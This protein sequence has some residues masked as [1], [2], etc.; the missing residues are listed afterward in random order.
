MIRELLEMM[1]VNHLSV[2]EISR[3]TGQN[4]QDLQNQV[5][6]LV[7]MGYMKKV[8]MDLTGCEGSC[9]GCQTKRSFGLECTEGSDDSRGT[10]PGDEKGPMDE[11]WGYELTEKGRKLV[12]KE[13]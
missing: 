11:I 6:M 1:F 2:E 3:S 8:R 7:H 9:S 12:I 10:G 4:M 13:R 5:D